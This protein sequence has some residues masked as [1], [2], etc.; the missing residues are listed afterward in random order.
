MVISGIFVV[1]SLEGKDAEGFET[2]ALCNNQMEENLTFR[3]YLPP[4]L[5]PSRCE[6]KAGSKAFGFA[7]TVTGYGVLLQGLDCDV[8]FDDK[9]NY[10]YTKTLTVDGACDFKDKLDVSKN[11]TSSTGDIK[12]NAGDVVA[13]T[14]S[15]K[16][17]VHP[18]TLTA[19]VEGTAGTPPT[20]L[21]VVAGGTATGTTNPPT[22]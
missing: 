1:Q 20:A 11:I 22:P 17:H 9:N 10:H 13:T 16:N 15:L 21:P 2:V 8:T 12:A 7:D 3:C 5:R 14:V 19:S 6:I 4:H 18:A